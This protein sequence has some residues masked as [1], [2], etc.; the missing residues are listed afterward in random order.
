MDAST[1][2]SKLDATEPPFR[3]ASALTWFGYLSFGLVFYWRVG[4]DR[5][6]QC[7]IEIQLRRLAGG[8]TR[9]V[10]LPD[11][12]WF[13]YLGFGLGNYGGIVEYG[14]AGLGCPKGRVWLGGGS[15][16]ARSCVPSQARPMVAGMTSTSIDGGCDNAIRHRTPHAH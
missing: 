12:T 13:G 8:H 7:W 14:V 3:L 4:L 11:L 10:G 9:F 15:W 1:M 2:A 6:K 5:R 16:A